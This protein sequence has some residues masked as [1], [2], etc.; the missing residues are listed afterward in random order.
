MGDRK[1][2]E[3]MDAADYIRQSRNMLRR[4]AWT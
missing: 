4:N 2:S 3:E 1:P